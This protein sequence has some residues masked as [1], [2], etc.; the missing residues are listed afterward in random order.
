MGAIITFYHKNRD[1]RLKYFTQEFYVSDT[2]LILY[3]CGEAD[4]Y[5]KSDIC[6]ARVSYDGGV[7]WGGLFEGVL[8]NG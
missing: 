4:S 1:K 3:S 5:A 8:K 6:D 2:E 7:T